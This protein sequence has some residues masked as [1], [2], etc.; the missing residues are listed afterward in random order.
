MVPDRFNVR[1]K[2]MHFKQRFILVIIVVIRT[3]KV[4][5][6]IRRR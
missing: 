4:K 3:I 1:S 2:R 6:V 5:I